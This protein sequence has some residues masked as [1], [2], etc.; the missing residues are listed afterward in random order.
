SPDIFTALKELNLE[1]ARGLLA[2]TDDDT[3]NLELALMAQEHNQ[4]MRV[5]VRQFDPHMATLLERSFDIQLSRSPSA[6]AAPAFAVAASAD[7][8]LDAFDLGDVLW[9]V[10]RLVIPKGHRLEGMAVRDL[11]RVEVLPLSLRRGDKTIQAPFDGDWT[12]QEGDKW[13]IVTPHD[14]WISWKGATRPVTP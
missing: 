8:L 10:G 7:D 11:W 3:L 14:R 6:I 5:V 1:E 4:H 2:V 12:L 13:V 9:C